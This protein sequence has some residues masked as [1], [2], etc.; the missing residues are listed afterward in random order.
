MIVKKIVVEVDNE[1]YEELLKEEFY[2]SENLEQ[3]VR[4]ILCED[5]D[6]ILCAPLEVKIN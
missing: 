5:C 3:Y 6:Y 2:G 1:Q 4:E